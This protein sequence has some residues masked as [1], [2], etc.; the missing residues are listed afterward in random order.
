MQNQNYILDSSRR[1]K[2]QEDELCEEKQEDDLCEEKQEMW[3]EEKE[4]NGEIVDEARE[5][6]QLL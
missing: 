1:T 6:K 2:K 3:K 5:E 4:E